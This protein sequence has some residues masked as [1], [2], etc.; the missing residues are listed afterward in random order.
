M[1]QKPSVGKEKCFWSG[2]GK[3]IKRCPLKATYKVR[4]IMGWNNYCT[5][6]TNLVMNNPFAFEKVEL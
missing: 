5:R 2:R 6:H 4:T 1:T 3:I